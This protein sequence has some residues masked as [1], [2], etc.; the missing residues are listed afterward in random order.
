MMK[1][2]LLGTTGF[3]GKNIKEV[4]TGR[5]DLYTPSRSELN[6]LNNEAVEH[7]L[8]AGH[9]D[10]IVHMANANLLTH[11]EW[12]PR[13]LEYNL[14]M[15]CN[16]ERCKDL[17]G[18]MLYFGSGAEYDMEHY[19]PQ[20]KESYFGTHIPKD[21]YGFSKYIM[22]KLAIGNVYDLRLFG[23]FGKYEEW[24]R[25]F[26]SN[27]IYQN[28]KGKTV[29]MNQNMY[30]DYLYIEDLIPVLEWFLT[31]EPKH[32]HYNVCSGRRVELL[33]LARMVLEET[34]K[35][36]EITVRQE[37]LKPEYTGDNSRL[38]AEMGS[39]RITPMRTAV[40]ELIQH[41]RTNGFQELGRNT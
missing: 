33:S 40:Q 1:L 21:P 30:F 37:G 26:I 8:R 16:L 35:P 7:Y 20:M 4:W 27:I 23:V 38:Q 31:N 24:Q 15:F 29:W 11:P 22:A 36:A 41:Y 28:L 5:Y 39:L 18:R 17:Y 13:A 34:G 14:R 3:I 25:R 2:L 32:H 6:L 9:F 10:V 19:I 12:S